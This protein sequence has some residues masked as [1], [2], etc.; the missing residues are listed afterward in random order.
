ML[1]ERALRVV[2]VV[3]GLFFAAGVYLVIRPPFKD[4]TFQM[5]LRDRKSVV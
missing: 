4:E 5:M 1:R 2:L 3:V